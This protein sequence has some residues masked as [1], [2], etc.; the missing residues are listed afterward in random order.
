MQLEA[1]WKEALQEEFEKPYFSSLARFVEE[2]RGRGPVYPPEAHVF[3]AFASC[4]FDQVK[5]VIVGQDP[6]HGPGQAHGLCFSVQKG[7]PLPPSLRNI[8]KE[9]ESDLGLPTPPHGCLTGWARQGAL[10]LN[11]TLTV[12]QS[13][14]MSHA[15]RGWETFT[16]AALK[17]L[18]DGR[19]PLAALLWG[20]HAKDTYFEAVGQPKPEHLILTA[21]HPSPLSATGFFGCRHFSKT[22]AFLEKQGLCP[23][24]F[25]IY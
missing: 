15:G 25:Q 22:N 16:T 10:L 6:Y 12:R 2:E 17:K 18:A 9:L 7:V 14:P 11:T 19:R 3:S 4:R 20:R 21:A 23:I 13:A 24:N 5:V 8:Y 1:S